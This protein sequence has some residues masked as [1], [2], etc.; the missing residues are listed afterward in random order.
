[1]KRDWRELEKEQNKI[2]DQK[3]FDKEKGKRQ[4]EGEKKEHN[5]Y[6]K[7]CQDSIAPAQWSVMIP[8]ADQWVL[9]VSDC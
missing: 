2:W 1:M 3:D 7:L 6:F 5:L 4:I 8:S 9:H